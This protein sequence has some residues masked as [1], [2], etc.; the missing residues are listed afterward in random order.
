MDICISALKERDIEGKLKQV[1]SEWSNQ[2]LTFAA[3][4]NRG[5]LLLRGDTTAEII[6]LLE[7]S[8][9]ILGSLQSN[10]YNA[11][12]K[13][14]IHKWVQDLS[15]TNEC[16][17]RWL[18]TQNM[19]VYLEA[20]FVGGDIAKQLPKEAK[21]FN[22]IDKSWVKIMMRAH[23]KSNVV[24]CCVGDD[25]L[26]QLFAL[27]ARTAGNLP[28]IASRGTK[29]ITK[30]KRLMFPRFFFVSDPALLEILGQASDSHS[31]QSHLLSIFD[32]TKSLI[33][34]D[35]DYN[36]ILAIVSS[37][38]ESI[39]LNKP[40]KAEGNVE[41]WLMNLLKMSH[42]SL[43]T[44]IRKAALSTTRPKFTL[45]EFLR[46]T[47]SSID[48]RTLMTNLLYV[49]HTKAFCHFV[50]WKQVGLLCLQIIW[51]RESEVA[52]AYSTQDKSDAANQRIILGIVE[53]AHRRDHQR[54][55]C[56]GAHQIRDL[57]YCSRSS[58][59]HLQRLG[60][61]PIPGPDLTLWK[62]LLLTTYMS[63]VIKEPPDGA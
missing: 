14:Q 43:H 51:T 53:H 4:K 36:R 18:F 35:K 11:P 26:K 8:L 63:G 33:F 48:K 6:S 45:M 21:R 49:Y 13:T 12:F 47:S 42:Q 5:E 54:S 39:T 10:R 55:G 61:W 20:V 15:N 59:R 40:V 28:E 44:V 52:L 32:N 30:K 9:M 34:D 7:D 23:E 24:E 62:S 58:K 41:S 17:E 1:K 38:G 16:L 46:G 27:P 37:E 50:Q 19:W 56:G 22:T 2:N 29:N 57:N 60:L 3:F 31:I 25:T